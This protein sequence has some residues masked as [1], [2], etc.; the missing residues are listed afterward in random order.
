MLGG[1]I[2]AVEERLKLSILYAG[3]FDLIMGSG[4]PE[5]DAFN[6]V[7][8]I[9]MPV[10]MLNGKYD[11]F[12]PY[13]TTV[14]PFYNLLGTPAADKKTLVYDTDHDV[15]ASEMIKETLNWL[16]KYFGPAK[17]KVDKPPSKP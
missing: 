13:E 7:S 16:D 3:G 10:L 1:I 5:A 15:P 14:I 12:F 11:S 8:R 4:L 2:P 6:Y 9:K 17:L